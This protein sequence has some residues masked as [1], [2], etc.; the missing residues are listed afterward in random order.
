MLSN[1]WLARPRDEVSADRPC[2]WQRGSV[3]S[4]PTHS[5]EDSRVTRGGAPRG[6]SALRFLGICSSCLLLAAKRT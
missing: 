5:C 3:Q 2:N 6:S 4:L 1:W